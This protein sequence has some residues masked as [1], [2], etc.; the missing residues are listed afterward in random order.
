[1]HQTLLI[2]EEKIARMVEEESRDILSTLTLSGGNF[3][4]IYH[5]W[6]ANVEAVRTPTKFSTH[7][8]RNPQTFQVAATCVQD[9]H[10]AAAGELL[11]WIYNIQRSKTITEENMDSNLS[12]YPVMREYE[13]SFNIENTVLPIYRK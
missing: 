4:I 10:L 12:K 5:P 2:R 9:L 7:K 11:T 3:T 13:A 1:M 6:N 8:K